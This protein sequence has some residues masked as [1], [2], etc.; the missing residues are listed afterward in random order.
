MAIST[1][2]AILGG[3]AIGGSLLGASKAAKAAKKAGQLQYQAGQ[4]ALQFQ[5]QAFDQIRQDNEPFRQIGLSAATALAGGLGLPVSMTGGAAQPTQAPATQATGSGAMTGNKASGGPATIPREPASF[6][7]PSAPASTGAPD[8]AEYGRENPDLQAEWQRIVS[9]GN[10][11]AFGNDPTAY[12]AWHW[13]KYGQNEGRDLPMTGGPTVP[14]PQTAAPSAPADG[15]APG[16]TDPTAPNGYD[17]GASPA[18]YV[19]PQRMTYAPLDVSYQN[20]ENSPDYKFRVQESQRALDNLSSSMGRVLSGARVKAAQ[21]RAQGLASQGYTDWRNYTTGQYNV[22]R[23]RADTIYEADRGFGYG[24]ARDARGDFVQDRARTDTRYDTRNN[25]LLNL[26][27]FGTGANASN[28]SS[29]QTFANNAGNLTMT[30]AQAQGNAAQ[31]AANAW[32]AG[33]N[34]IMTTGAYLW[35]SGAFGGAG[36]GAGA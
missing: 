9:T 28:A 12:Y 24:Q 27:G 30:G 25:T 29:A 7:P 14:A 22:D 18:P 6:A 17:A 35:G 3:A 2:A 32:N 31:N 26:A 20:F 19:S 5:R 15:T 1:T 16:Y 33:L 21:E 4:D 13:Q 11:S 34:N 10:A 8:Y 36:A 23:N